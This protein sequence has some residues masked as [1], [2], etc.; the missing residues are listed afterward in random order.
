MSRHLSIPAWAVGC[1]LAAAV[2]AAEPLRL[3]AAL[4]RARAASP[5]LMAQDAELLATQARADHEGLPPPYVVGADLENV[6]GTGSLGGVQGAEATA[7]IGR[8]IELGGKRAARRELGRAEVLL[9]RHVAAAERLDVA[10][11]TTAR[12]IEVL[13]DQQR[14]EY[15]R[16]RV[17]LAG[18]LR[19]EVAAWVEVA[20][21]PES[22]LHA[23]Q[24]AVA[25]A[26]LQ[27]EHAEHELLSART[28]LAASW[29]ALLPDFTMAA[30]D[31]LQL[32]PLPDF[33]ALAARLPQ[34]PE[35]QVLR[36]Q[37]D[38][39][40][41]R[42]RIAYAA[43]QPDV[44]V[45][46]G[47]RRLEAFDDQGLVMSFS[48]PLGSRARAAPGVAEAEAQLAAQ[49]ARREA[50]LIERHQLMFEK[51]QELGHARAEVDTVTG[52]MLPLAESALQFT[53]RGF[54]VG[55][56]G[57]LELDQAQRAVFDLRGRAV[58]AATRYHF[59][60]AEVER[61]AALPESTP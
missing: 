43:G 47:V 14:L 60:L 27:L 39:L 48:L 7:R 28:T 15:A 55:R 6:A 12:F 53:R 8:L 36:L 5:A 57:F 56:F 18:R 4:A 25:E 16:E 46:I 10:T 52:R 26:E 3:E 31:L 19:D 23:A 45:S 1:C 32:P 17:L 13:A 2:H 42:R 22:D 35:Q 21:N 33:A 58:E 29:G 44:S 24:I 37:A 40:E 61:L 50:D 38:S 9:Q 20:R 49:Q 11:R 34:T 51:Y 41:A 59:L 30:G 54:E